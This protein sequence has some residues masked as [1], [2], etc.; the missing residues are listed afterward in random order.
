LFPKHHR[1]LF[2][3]ILDEEGLKLD[4]EERPHTA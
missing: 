3:T 2:N 1:E 4:R